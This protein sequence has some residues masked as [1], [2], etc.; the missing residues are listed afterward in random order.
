LKDF[1]V[2]EWNRINKVSE[3]N[4]EMALE[5]SEAILNSIKEISAELS[6]ISLENS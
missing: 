5:K 3:E 4:A 6:A 2:S 1:A